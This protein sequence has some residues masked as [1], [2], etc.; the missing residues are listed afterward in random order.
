MQAGLILLAGTAGKMVVSSAITPVVNSTITLI[1]SLRTNRT[2][3]T[4]QDIITKY[5][6]PAT[7]QTI[8]RTCVALKCDKEPLKTAAS[9][10]V[11][12]V[13]HIHKL[14]TRIADIT[15][16]HEAG[17]ISRWRVLILDVEIE[18]L[19]ILMDILHQRFKLM[20]DIRSVTS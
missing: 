6:I 13:Q 7:L 5:D 4:L 15:A 16:S 9:H 1:T 8:E 10:V 3:P 19:K 11:E 20:C 14:L 2:H 17:Y 12:A 18:Q